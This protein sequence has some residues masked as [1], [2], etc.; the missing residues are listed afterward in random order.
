M[1]TRRQA[2][3]LKFIDFSSKE[4]GIAPSFDEMTAGLGLRSKSGV[5]RLITALEERG[6]IRRLRN[7]AR[8]IQVVRLPGPILADNTA[9]L[10]AVMLPEPVATLARQAAYAQRIELDTLVR[11]AVSAYLGIGLDAN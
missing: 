4:Q 9:G 11:E 2:D 10:T 8:A 5:H 7:R 1:L 3:L 6:Y